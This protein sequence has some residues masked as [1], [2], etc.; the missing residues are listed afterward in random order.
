MDPLH[1]RS[2]WEERKEKNTV[3]RDLLR[4]YRG[5]MSRERIQRS[6]QISLQECQRSGSDEDN[7]NENDPESQNVGSRVSCLR[8]MLP[9][10]RCH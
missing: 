3:G 4:A 5:R 6:E 8:R 1:E 10:G 9:K 2:L 7:P